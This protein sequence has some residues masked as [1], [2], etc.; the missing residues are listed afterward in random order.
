MTQHPPLLQLA[1]AAALVLSMSTRAG[2]APQ[3][4]Y[5]D[6]VDPDGKAFPIM[7]G[8]PLLLPGGDEQFGTSDDIY[9]PSFTGDVDLVVRVGTI[10]AAAIPPPNGAPGGPARQT[11]TAGGGVTGQGEEVSF[12]VMV[13]DSS[14]SPAY[15]NVLMVG[16]LDYRPIT[17]FA[18][19]DLDADGV[20]GP[21]NADPSGSADN[22]IEEQE[23]K[24]FVGRQVGFLWTGRAQGSLGLQIAA[25]ASIGGLTVSLSAG[26]YTG[27]DPNEFYGDGTPIFTLWPYFPPL[28]SHK[29]IG[30]DNYGPLDPTI[31]SEIIFTPDM[32]YLPPPEHPQLGTLF[33]IP[34]DG[35]EPSTDQLTVV[36]GPA[37]GARFFDEIDPEAFRATS[38]AWIRPAPDSE[39]TGRTLVAPVDELSFPA[40]GATT[41]RKL[42]LLPVDLFGNVADPD[43]N[44]GFT[45]DLVASG[46]VYIASPSSDPYPLSER[47]LLSSAVGTEVLIG[48]IGPAADGRIDL[49]RPQTGRR[50]HVAGS[51]AVNLSSGGDRD[52]DGIAD[53]NDNCTLVSNRSQA[54]VDG[55]GLGNCCDGRCAADPNSAGCDECGLSPEALC[56]GFGGDTDGDTLCDSE[57]P[58]RFF[59]NSLPLTTSG[60]SGIPDECLCGDVTGD[61]FLTGSDAQILN[62]CAGFLRFDCDL[63]R[64]DV[65][66]DGVLTGNDAAQVNRV[67]GFLLPAYLLTCPR[68]PEGTCGGATGVSC[69]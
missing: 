38:R 7:P 60:F 51:L 23:A 39:G 30:G 27:A 53:Q 43:P 67:A 24:A 35:S 10:G 9:D 45:I 4:F 58:C 8:L 40:D 59:H 26:A 34:L 11:S 47:I 66:G 49:L 12:T 61:H 21:T 64:D 52:A 62:H 46:G 37:S 16:D 25:P 41:L 56:D 63:S 3:V 2:L 22:A 42:R 28:D 55:D 50:S 68:R 54:D 18:F 20:L 65:D 31:R 1:L 6:P 17:V 57:D 15:G 32:N 29:V 36:S 14:G 13:S 48:H 5:G 44:S 19:A 69:F 33:A